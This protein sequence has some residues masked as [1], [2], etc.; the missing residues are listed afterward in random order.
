ML[1]IRTNCFCAI[2]AK[3][4]QL[5]NCFK[6]LW[7]KIE[8]LS[9]LL[10]IVYTTIILSSYSIVSFWDYNRGFE[11]SARAFCTC[12][13][14]SALVCPVIL[15]KVRKLSISGNKQAITKQ[16]SSK[17]IIWTFLGSLAYFLISY[18][19][20]YPG[21]LGT[22]SFA[23]YD[24]A[25]TGLYNDWHPFFHTLFAFKLPLA[26]TKGWPGSIILFQIILFAAVITY[27]VHTVLIY[28]N[29]TCALLTL[30]FYLINPNTASLGISALKDSSFAIG[31]LLLTSYAMQIFFTKGSWICK[32]LNSL[33]FILAFVCTTLFRHNAILFTAPLLLAVLLY[34]PRLNK[35][36]IAA[37]SIILLLVVK[38]PVYNALDV[39]APGYRNSETLGL[40]LN[41]I[42]SVTAYNPEALDDETRVFAHSI[43]PQ[44][45]W[46][47]CYTFGNYNHFKYNEHVNK[48][49]IE[50]R[51]AMEIIKMS[52]NCVLRSPKE[53]LAGLIQ[54]TDP[55]YTITDDYKAIMDIDLANNNYQIQQGGIGFLRKILSLASL[56]ITLLLAHLVHFIGS[57]MLLLLISMLAKCNLCK[58]SDWK[59]ILLILPVFAYNFGTMLLMTHRGDALRFF[60]YTFFLVPLYLIILFT[61]QNNRR[62]R[63][64]IPQ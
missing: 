9:G 22:D 26:I 40:P 53:A 59:K 35:I 16:K 50:E 5:M 62:K 60:Q 7:K 15:R 20:Y 37:L 14:F 64:I 39:E 52:I 8:G 3:K 18:I 41:I 32:P 24:Q 34:M 2:H 21:G 11:Y 28:T 25:V 47:E 48:D 6:T 54:L 19:A 10:F 44:H 45:I 23:Q 30:V 57:M 51:S 63:D 42:A 12:F 4:G 49:P 36:I 55:I 33:L 29:K 43:A 27:S 56:A 17:W 31:A 58:V 46:E 61:N 1:L 38:V 13:F